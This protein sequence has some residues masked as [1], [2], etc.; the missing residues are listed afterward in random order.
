MT[1]TPLKCSVVKDDFSVSMKIESFPNRDSTVFMEKFGMSNC[2]TFIRGT[3][4]FVGFSDIISSFHDIG[5]TSDE[6]AD[7]DVKT[8]R[9]LLESK[10]AGVHKHNS[11][12]GP[13]AVAFLEKVT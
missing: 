2:E 13:R 5:L 12:L 3:L 10:I 9:D 1:D 11:S 8:L 6:P 4:R 7:K